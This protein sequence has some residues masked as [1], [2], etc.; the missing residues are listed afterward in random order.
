MT[1][2]VPNRFRWLEGFK[3]TNKNNSARVC[4]AQ[5]FDGKWE[6]ACLSSIRK[7]SA[8]AIGRGSQANKGRASIQ[9]MRYA[10]YLGAARNRRGL[11]VAGQGFSIKFGNIKGAFELRDLKGQGLSWVI[12]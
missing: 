4:P 10:Y 2:L 3:T 8:W 7:P 5:E 9:R 12:T 6:T 1:T 11:G